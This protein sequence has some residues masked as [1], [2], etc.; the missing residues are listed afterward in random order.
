MYVCNLYKQY[1]CVRQHTNMCMYVHMCCVCV[2][3]C[4]YD[5]YVLLCIIYIYNVGV[6]LCLCMYYLLCMYV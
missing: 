6:Y 3:E 1:M 5:Y 4:V 2:Y